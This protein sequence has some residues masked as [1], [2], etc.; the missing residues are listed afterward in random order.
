MNVNG[1]KKLELL[2]EKFYQWRARKSNKYER[3]PQGLWSEAHL[4]HPTF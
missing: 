3:I 2:V 4:P 1:E